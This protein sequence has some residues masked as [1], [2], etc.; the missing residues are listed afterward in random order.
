M[1]TYGQYCP[2]ARAS[3]VLA[4]RWTPIILR[5]L[6]SGPTS[7]SA[8]ADGAPGLS[9]S[10]LT[11]RLREL[12]DVGLV[13]TTPAPSGTRE[14]YTLTESGRDLGPVLTALGEWGERW[15]EVA[16]GHADPGYVLNSWCNRYLAIELL[17]RKRVTARFEF[18]D[19]P[20]SGTPLW[21]VFQGS[22]S[23]VCRNYPGYYEDLVVRAESVALAEWHLG[24]I[25]WSD[26]LR[27]DRV[28]V[29]GPPSLSRAL[30]TWNKRSNWARQEDLG[31]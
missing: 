25:E 26:A 27:A 8:L 5:D 10:L 23:E 21:F 19:Q 18:P 14:L 16:P 24:R 31:G 2:I 3:E 11:T 7:F 28:R 13:E 15:L 30:P 4:Q 17:P 22:D 29:T 12:Q 1:K 9:R 6:Q 20:A